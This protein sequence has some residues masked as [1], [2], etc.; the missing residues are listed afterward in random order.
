MERRQSVVG[1]EL[2]GGERRRAG[3]DGGFSE[4]EW[5]VQ[6]A[7]L[8]EQFSEVNHVTYRHLQTSTYLKSVVGEIT[9]QYKVPLGDAILRSRM[10]EPEVLPPSP[11]EIVAQGAALAALNV[12]GLYALLSF[13][14]FLSILFKKCL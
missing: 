1:S 6:A 7:D 2:S 14:L 13:S 10:Q 9:G 5:D 4:K 3:Y 12:L 8:A 11:T